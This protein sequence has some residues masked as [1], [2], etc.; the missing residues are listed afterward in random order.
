MKKLLLGFVLLML[1]TSCWN[2]YEEGKEI[3]V[4]NEREIENKIIVKNWLYS[5]ITPVTFRDPKDI[6]KFKED[7]EKVNKQI[8]SNTGGV[9]YAQIVEKA[10][11]LDYLWKTWEALEL[12]VDNFEN[13]TNNK[14]LAYSHNMARLYE[15]LEAYD[16]ALKRYWFLINYFKRKDYY[17][18]VANI[19]KKRWDNEKYEQAINVYN[20]TINKDP[21]KA[22]E[23]NVSSDWVIELK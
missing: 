18:D 7:L 17:K 12:Y 2:K 3:S 11:L 9:T 19:W 22:T 8:Q 20:K 23:V 1:L 4:V 16:E 21:V 5:K 14:S 13:N 10:R 15:K 6:A